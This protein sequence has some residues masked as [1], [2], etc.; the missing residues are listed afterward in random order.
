MESS[1]RVFQ[2]ADEIA[3]VGTAIGASFAGALAATAT[4]GPGMALKGEFINLAVMT[5][6]PLV[7]IN[8]QRGGPSTGLPTK[9][10]QADLFQALYGRNGDSP[11]IVIAADSPSNCF[12]SVFEA[13][14]YA[15]KYMTPV[16]LLTDGNL[17]YGSEPLR[18]PN[19]SELPDIVPAWK[20]NPPKHGDVYCPYVREEHTL[21]RPWVIPGTLGY[22]H[23]IGGLEKEDITGRVSDDPL[24]HERMTLIRNEKI[25]KAAQEYAPLEVG[26]DSNADLLIIGWGSTCGVIRQ[27]VDNM[28]NQGIPVA[29]LHVRYIHPFPSDMKAIL[30]RYNKVLVVENNLGQLNHK[31][32]AEF[33]IDTELL[34]KVQGHR[35]NVHEVERKAKQLIGV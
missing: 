13:A 7:V 11:L 18:I 8:V 34:T 30:S 28:T 25:Q 22:E 3:A 12:Y 24:N 2:A 1:V 32:R 19:L 17:A 31:I 35:F 10:E 20:V 21:A 27:A 26:G 6:L 23:C 14:Y 16:I 29:C 4:S 15:I 9:S 5:E 33:L